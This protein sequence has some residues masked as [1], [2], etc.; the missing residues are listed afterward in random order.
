[1][2]VSET[3][4]AGVLIITPRVFTDERGFFK[5]T[6]N[7]QRYRNEAG[8]DLPFVQDN[9]AHSGPGVLRGLHF[10]KTRP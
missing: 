10:Q 2:N 8:I 9:D 5:E 4:L 7:A 3:M 6:Y 1:M